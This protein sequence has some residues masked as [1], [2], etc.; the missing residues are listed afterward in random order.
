[1][2]LELNNSGSWKI[3]LHDIDP[4]HVEAVRAAVLELLAC[5]RNQRG[6]CSF[7][8]T[9]LVEPRGKEA[10]GRTLAITRGIGP[11]ATWVRGA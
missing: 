7:A 3:V 4:E 9:E 1:M 10:Y 8:L 6:K 5:D 2:R 11:S